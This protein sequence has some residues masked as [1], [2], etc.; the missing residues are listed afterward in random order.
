MSEKPTLHEIAAMPY[1]ASVD[2]MR[3]FYNPTWGMPIPDDGE[4]RQ[5][6]VTVNYTVRTEDSRTYQVEAFSAEEAE[7]EADE[8]F[9]KDRSVEP[10][11]EVE[12]FEVEEVSQ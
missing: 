9:G 3:K 4:L 2:A 12:D 7:D 1:P 6:K 11:A 10:D 8:M 5:F